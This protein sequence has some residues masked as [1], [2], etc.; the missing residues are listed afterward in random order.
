MRRTALQQLVFRFREARAV[1]AGLEL[2][3]FE[4]LDATPKTAESLAI[5]LEL[6]PRGMQ[7]LLGALTAIGVIRATQGGY[8]ADPDTSE[9]LRAGT[10][11]SLR[12]LWLH[13][14]WHWSS[15]A[16]LDDVVRRG[17]AVK[18]HPED[19][20]LG[21]P[22]VLKDFLPNYTLAME[23]SLDPS[24]KPLAE[25]IAARRP[26]Q[27]MDV[28][29]GSGT[30]LLE[31]LERLPQANARLVEHGF[32]LE[33]ARELAAGHPCGQRLELLQIDA[34][35]EDLPRGQDL[36]ILSRVLMGL[37]PE[38]AQQLLRSIA[39]CLVEGGV[40]VIHDFDPRSRVGALMSLDML[41]N[42]GGQVYD[43]D[44]I[45]EWLNGCGFTLESSAPILPYT[46][47]FTATRR[48]Q[49]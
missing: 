25:H 32:A 12:S 33:R 6:D 40:L 48:R 22:D 16:R 10:A 26:G 27:V 28:G 30:L 34:M 15:W 24:V 19:P 21:S 11:E 41:L 14:L 3:L 46:Q 43:S 29:G 37:G 4:R 42:T 7:V 49:P 9:L 38:A 18:R 17:A 1:L 39:A 47:L 20:H 44:T 5:T 36:V 2:G 31:V 23:Q 45:S 13:D 35:R 8:I